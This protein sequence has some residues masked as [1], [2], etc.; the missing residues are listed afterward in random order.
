[1]RNVLITNF[2]SVVL[3]LCPLVA[4]VSGADTDVVINEI[5]YHPTHDLDDLQYIELYNRGAAVVELS[6]WSFTKGIKF[7][8]PDKARLSPG[9]YLVVC[10]KVSVFS[11]NYGQNIPVLGDFSGN[12][13]HGGETI[14]LSNAA[15]NVI[16]TVR[17]EDGDLWPMGPDGYSPSLERIC[18][19][20]NGAD[21]SNWA[22]S[23]LPSFEKP[24]GTPGRKNDSFSTNL[25]PAISHVKFSAPSFLQPVTVTAEIADPSGVKSVTL[26]WRLIKSGGESPESSVPMSRSGGDDRK[27]V[28]Q[29]II[30]GQP[31]GK[32]VRFRIK[33]ANT[34]GTIRLMP[35]PNEPRPTFSY[36]TFTNANK[37]KIAFAYVFNISPPQSDST[38]QVWNPR[39]YQVSAESTSGGAAFL[40]SPPGSSEVITFDHVLVRPRNGGFKVHF[41]KDQTFKGMTGINI[42]SEGMPR[43]LLSEP[44]AYELYRLAG[45]PAPLTEHLRTWMDGQPLGY[46]L[47]IEQPNKAFL[48]RNKRDDFGSLYKVLWYEQGLVGQHEKKTR[49]ATESKDLVT[50]YEGLTASSGPTQSEFIRKNF[51]VDEFANYYAVNMCI[52]NWDGFFNNYFLYHPAE[53]TQKWEMYPWDEDKTWG[54]YDGG[55]EDCDWYSMPLTFG[56]EDGAGRGRQRGFGGGAGWWRPPGWFSG[57]LLVNRE[58]RK[59]FLTRLNQICVTI[60][61]EEKII[62]LIDAMEKRL[63]PE[64]S[65]RAKLGGEDPRSAM[66][67]FRRDITSLRNQVKY[68]RQF[69]I[70][71]IPKDKASQ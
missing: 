51:N 29:A 61:T 21:P 33:A 69:I 2:I 48:R 57:P 70:D 43:S 62:P 36:S 52:Q 55:S 27:G 38:I 35:S 18:P 32:L 64:I 8:F 15:G 41:L 34:P 59:I 46:H 28:Y 19:S 30:A 40:Y 6:K 14:E 4:T 54:Y 67:E 47:L 22:G 71:A 24:A 17:Y 49:P 44:L 12:L 50:L 13:S 23:T 60:F 37:A 1:M 26:L 9:K 58:F 25:P 7:V 31:A 66:S 16:D 20:V 53:G 45:V 10:R 5:M 3:S 11:P 65:L 39:Q 63:E 42:I 56:M 68:R